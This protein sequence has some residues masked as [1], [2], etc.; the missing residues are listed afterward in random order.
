MNRRRASD[1]RVRTSG[2]TATGLRWPPRPPASRSA[3]VFVAYATDPLMPVD[4]CRSP[5]LSCRGAPRTTRAVRSSLAPCVGARVRGRVVDGGDGLRRAHRHPS[6]AAGRGPDRIVARPGTGRGIGAPMR[7]GVRAWAARVL[8]PLRPVLAPVRRRLRRTDAR[9]RWTG[10][11]AAANPPGDA[12]P[13]HQRGRVRAGRRD[14]AGL[15]PRPSRLH[16]GRRVG[17]GRPHRASRSAHGAGARPASP[18]AGHRVGRDGAPATGR[19]RGCGDGHRPRCDAGP[20][21]GSR[22]RL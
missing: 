14:Q 2:S 4:P 10:P 20:V 19:T 18:A 11:S 17:R 1:P 22:P 7:G 8:R 15:L 12:D 6:G 9:D 16:L 3:A 5:T 21:A 13:R